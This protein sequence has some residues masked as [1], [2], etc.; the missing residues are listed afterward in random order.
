MAVESNAAEDALWR[1]NEVLAAQ[2]TR[3]EARELTQVEVDA[4][5]EMLDQDKMMRRL[6]ASART[7][8][9]WIAAVVAGFTL[10]LDALKALLRKLLA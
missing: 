8:S 6:W 2:I 7:W 10:G 9:L 1:A 5:R 4:L 3:L